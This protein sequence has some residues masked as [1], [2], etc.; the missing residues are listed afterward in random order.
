[1]NGNKSPSAHKHLVLYV[2][3]NPYIVASHLKL[4]IPVATAIVTAALSPSVS[5]VNMW[6]ANAANP[7]N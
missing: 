7:N 5:A 4:L 3:W 2:R 1:M 6:C